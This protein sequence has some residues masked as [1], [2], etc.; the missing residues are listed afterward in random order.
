MSNQSTATAGF[1][2]N[3]DPE[4]TGIFQVVGSRRAE[5]DIGKLRKEIGDREFTRIVG[6]ETKS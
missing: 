1:I 4:Q 6:G 2:I 3:V 5:T